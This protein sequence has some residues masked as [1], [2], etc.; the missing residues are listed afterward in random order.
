MYCFIFRRFVVV[1]SHL[2]G[3]DRLCQGEGLQCLLYVP[4]E[5]T[6]IRELDNACISD[7]KNTIYLV[8]K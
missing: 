4:T 8:D 3:T 6:S 5:L 1:D 2:V 7:I